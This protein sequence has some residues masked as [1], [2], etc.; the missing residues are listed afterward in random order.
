VSFPVQMMA[1]AAF[2]CY[3]HATATY[4]PGKI[5]SAPLRANI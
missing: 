3:G 2:M 5:H 4:K 1:A